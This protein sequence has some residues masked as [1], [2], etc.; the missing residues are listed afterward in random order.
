MKKI[1]LSTVLSTTFLTSAAFC[2]EKTSM[3]VGLDYQMRSNSL[4]FESSGISVSEKDDSKAFKLKFGTNSSENGW[5]LQG[6]LKREIYDI[7]IF[8]NTHDTLIEFGFDVIKCFEVTP[9]F[10]PF[11]QV[12]LGYGFMNVDGYSQD[13]IKELNFKFGAGMM[14]KISPAVEF[15]VGVDYQAKQW[16]DVEILYYTVSTTEKST[17]YYAGVNFHF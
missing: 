3:Y 5:R 14:Y 16:Q 4:T 6:Y 12:G 9:E 7:P 13:I 17:Q 11:L 1:I 8:D 2:E 15:L 10:S